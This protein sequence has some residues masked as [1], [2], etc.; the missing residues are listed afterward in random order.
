[1]VDWIHQCCDLLTPLYETLNVSVLKCKYLQ[2]DET[3]IPVL[4]KYKLGAT[5]KGY[6]LVYRDMID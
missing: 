2:A 5:H 3:P 1:M 4:T 6:L